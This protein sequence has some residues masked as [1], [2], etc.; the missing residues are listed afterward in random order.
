M[1][2]IENPYN[3]ST[4]RESGW[5]FSNKALQK[6]SLSRSCLDVPERKC[7]D[8][9]W[10]DQWVISHICKW[11][12][13]WGYNSL[14]LTIDPNFLGHPSAQMSPFSPCCEFPTTTTRKFWRITR[15]PTYQPHQKVRRSR[16][17]RRYT[18]PKANMAGWKSPC[19]SGLIPSPN[20]NKIKP[21]EMYSRP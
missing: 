14:I 13:R 6:K 4:Q 16:R 15:S 20:A 18:R 11:D 17:P 5:R 9:W 7:W 21:S 8:Q 12:I 10:S 3:P 19:L 1:A 2:S